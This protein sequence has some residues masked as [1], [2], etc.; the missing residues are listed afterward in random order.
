MAINAEMLN[1]LIPLLNE[2]EVRTKWDV[3]TGGNDFFEVT[4][5]FHNAL[6]GDPYEAKQEHFDIFLA[7]N[8][9]NRRLLRPDT[10]FTVIHDPQ[11]VG[12]IDHFASRQAKWIWRGHID[13]STPNEE[14]FDVLL[15]SI[16]RYDAAIFHLREY[17]PKAEGL[18][19]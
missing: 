18:P 4:K 13:F 16:R 5:A 8:E 10:E 11:P 19:E 9:R 1:R 14:I 6:H 7:Y 12:M 17:V 3:I 2:V 15:P